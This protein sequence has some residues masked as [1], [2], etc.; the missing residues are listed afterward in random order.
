MKAKAYINPEKCIGCGACITE[1]PVHAIVMLPGWRSEVQE[2]HWVR[3]LRGNLPQKSAGV[4]WRGYSIRSR[5]TA[6]GSLNNTVFIGNISINVLV[7]ILFDG[8]L[9]FCGYKRIMI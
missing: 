5:I 3:T 6:S 2:M 7:T 1:C 8:N 9:I 4:M